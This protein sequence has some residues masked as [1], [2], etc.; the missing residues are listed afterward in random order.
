MPLKA[1]K[2]LETS[3]VKLSF[4]NKAMTAYG[5]F[6]LLAKLFE[7]LELRENIERLIPFQE[8]SPNSTG[9]FAHVRAALI[10]SG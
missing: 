10:S 6:A 8:I 9:V 7:K 4:T 1:I 5:G 3:R 2:F